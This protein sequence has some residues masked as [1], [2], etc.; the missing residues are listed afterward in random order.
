MIDMRN[1]QVWGF[2]TGSPDTYP[3]NPL[4]SKPQVSRPF[5]LG[6]F[7]LEDTEQ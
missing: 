2:P 5:A 1:G 7:A 3:S 6:R 4:Q